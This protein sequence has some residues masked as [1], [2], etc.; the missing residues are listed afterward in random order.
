MTRYLVQLSDDGENWETLTEPG[1]EDPK[2]GL[3]HSIYSCI[4][5]IG[6][7]PAVRRIKV[8]GNI[9]SFFP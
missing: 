2:V 4:L 5:N 6:R 3:P 8:T 7:R 1:T 9:V